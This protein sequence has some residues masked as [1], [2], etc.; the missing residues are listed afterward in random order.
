MAFA[1]KSSSNTKGYPKKVK[2]QPFIFIKH[3]KI[4]TLPPRKTLKLKWVVNKIKKNIKEMKISKERGNLCVFS[5]K[6]FRNIS[7]LVHDALQKNSLSLFPFA[8]KLSLLFICLC[9][10]IE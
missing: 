2:L 1:S 4:H 8:P 10:R 3:F 5:V 6:F 7:L 9:K